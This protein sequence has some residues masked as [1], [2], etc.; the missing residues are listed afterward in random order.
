MLAVGCSEAVSKEHAVKNERRWCMWQISGLC[1]CLARPSM[2]L[3]KVGHHV[4]SD[5]LLERRRKLCRVIL[6]PERSATNAN[7]LYRFLCTGA[8][9][10][11]SYTAETT[12]GRCYVTSDRSIDASNIPF[13]GKASY[14]LA[15]SRGRGTQVL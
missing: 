13:R 4:L 2:K 3:S 15:I 10:W 1:A 9:L 11:Q 14:G 6:C 8:V 5:G 12:G 7:A